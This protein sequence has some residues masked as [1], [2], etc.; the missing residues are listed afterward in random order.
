MGICYAYTATQLID[1]NRHS[2]QI[3][4]NLTPDKEIS[5]PIFTAVNT[6]EKWSRDGV[7]ETE[8][9]I[10]FPFEGS[11]LCKAF[12]QAKIIGVC[13]RSAID[14]F[15]KE[16]GMNE[17]EFFEALYEIE[18]RYA[19]KIDE[20]N[21]AKEQEKRE[22]WRMPI[23]SDTFYNLSYSNNFSLSM[24]T[25]IHY[26]EK[27]MLCEDEKANKLYEE[28]AE[29]F[30]DTFLPT[31]EIFKK[32]YSH[33]LFKQQNDIAVVFSWICPKEKRNFIAQQK[34]CEDYGRDEVALEG[35]KQF[36]YI[37]KLLEKLQQTS[38]PIGISYCSQLLKK[39]K[40][41]IGIISK[42]KDNL[43]F[44]TT[45]DGKSLCGAHSSLVIGSRFNKANKT[46]EF[47]IR[48]TWGENCNYHSDFECEKGQIWV[49]HH[50]LSKNIF[51]LQ[52]I[53]S[54]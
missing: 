23:Q 20:N 37:K 21:L 10:K 29:T 52:Y 48:N 39:G 11:T 31:K 46:C 50:T 2:T 35:Q 36:P 9:R 44:K 22:I 3:D 30:G 45:A 25:E 5:S 53:S 17:R 34:Y 40:N 49:D 13:P 16:R 14:D 26:Q 18:K 15:L 54:D 12:N 7:Q 32:Y 51:S 28:L 24:K 41:H 19:A 38:L 6:F 42:T 27:N 8:E 4:K 43:K 47:L 1:A 33:D